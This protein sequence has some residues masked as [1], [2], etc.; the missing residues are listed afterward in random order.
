MET[1]ILRT[2][3]TINT[4]FLSIC[5]IKSAIL[6]SGAGEGN[7][8]RALARVALRGL[9]LAGNER[10]V[11]EEHR[12]PLEHVLER[13]HGRGRPVGGRLPVFVTVH[14]DVVFDLRTPAIDARLPAREPAQDLR[15][16]LEVRALRVFAD[17]RRLRREHRVIQEVDEHAH[18]FRTGLEYREHGL[19]A[20]N[21]TEDAMRLAFLFQYL[22]ELL[23]RALGHELHQLGNVHIPRMHL[24]LDLVHVSHSR[25]DGREAV[26]R[27]NQEQNNS[28]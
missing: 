20:R 8:T 6:S 28:D 7:S 5:Q 21:R 10:A 11:H 15:L 18:A 12:V 1:V 25:L 22:H 2:S 26:H 19:G 9:E 27:E 23:H 24:H 17:E 14:R 4:Y 16:T 13:L 3:R